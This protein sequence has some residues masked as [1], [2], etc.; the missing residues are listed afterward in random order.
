MSTATDRR[1]RT[2]PADGEPAWDLALLFP[3]QG[4]WTEDEYLALKQK[5]NWPIELS[6]GRLEVL[7]MPTPFHQRIVKFLFKL[8]EAFI[9]GHARGEVFVS[10]LPVRLWPGKLREP[11]VLYLRPGRI[12]DA[13]RPPDGADLAMEVVSDGDENRDRD[14]RVKREEYA[15]AGIAEYWIVDPRERTITVLVLD[16]DAYRV[17]GAF[18]LGSTANSCMFPGFQVDVTATFAAGETPA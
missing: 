5:T 6:D 4:A 10:P 17:H 3:P 18:G 11:D 15:K 16:G 7:A 13:L 2:C 12:K 14:L 8:L 9:L 1:S